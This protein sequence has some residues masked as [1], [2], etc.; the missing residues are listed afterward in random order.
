AD[1]AEDVAGLVEEE[2]ALG[3]AAILGER[4]GAVERLSEEDDR[5]RSR[6]EAEEVRRRPERPVEVERVEDGRARLVAGAAAAVLGLDR[7]EVRE[8]VARAR[9]GARQALGGERGD[10]AGLP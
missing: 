1:E 10:P 7:F 4:G 6:F 3:A 9:Q 5:A 2:H 8:V